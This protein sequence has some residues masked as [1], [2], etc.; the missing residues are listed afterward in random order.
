MSKMEAS[1]DLR[2]VPSCRSYLLAARYMIECASRDERQNEVALPV[3]YLALIWERLRRAG[4]P[5]SGV[6]AA[7]A[8]PGG[9]AIVGGHEEA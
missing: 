8:L 6:V 5:E 3:A 2:G 9:A 4:T 7:R 1:F